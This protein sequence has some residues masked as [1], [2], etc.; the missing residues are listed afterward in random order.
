MLKNLLKFKLSMIIVGIVM[1]VVIIIGIISTAT[2]TAIGYENLKKQS[3]EKRGSVTVANNYIYAERYRTLLNS[4]LIND[5]Y[6]SLERLVF[7]L[8]RT[9]N[10]LDATTLSYQEWEQAYLNNLNSEKKQMI[11]IKTICKQIKMDSNIPEY[12]IESDTNS[13]G[14]YIEKLNLC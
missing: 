14:V 2:G 1:F 5:G 9:H 12:T 8:Q 10:S 7:Y 6:V 13:N 3:E 4:H 11:P